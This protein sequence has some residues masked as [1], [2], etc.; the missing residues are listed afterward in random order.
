DALAQ[1]GGPGH[2]GHTHGEGGDEQDVHEDVAGGGSRQEQEGGLAVAQ[3]REDA[4][5]HVVEEHEG[6]AQDVDVQIQGRVGQDF[7]RGVD[8]LQQ[9][10]AAEQAH[11]HQG[12]HQDG[13]ADQGSGDGGFHVLVLLCA[14]EPGHDD[15]TADVAAKGEGNEDQGDLIAVAY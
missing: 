1:E 12:G 6:Q 4:G 5:G 14:E 7:L 2:A 8:E 15:G 11:R 10:V 13:T 3:G 9:S